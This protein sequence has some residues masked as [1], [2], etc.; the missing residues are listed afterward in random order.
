MSTKTRRSI[1]Q[2]RNIQQLAGA[3]PVSASVQTNDMASAPPA[4]EEALQLIQRIQDKRG[5]PLLTFVTVPEVTVRSD[6]VE[7]VYEQLR[8]I[9]HVPQIDLFLHSAGGQTEVPWRL[10]TLI[11]DFADR[12]A[13]L[14]P[15][16]AYSAATHLAM[17]AD[18][19]IMGPRSELS[20]VDPARAHPLLPGRAEG[21]PPLTVSVQDLRRCVEF[22][23]NEIGVGSPDA[24]AQVIVALFEK[25]H[26]LAIGA[27]QQ[28]YD[29]ARLISR[30]A[31]ATHMDPQTDHDQIERIVNALS[32]EF[33]SHGYWIGWQE[34]QQ[35]GLKVVR[36]DD[37]LW[38]LMWALYRHYKS[39]FT[40]LR[41]TG[42]EREA[43]RPIAWIDSALQ[44]RI[45]EEVYVLPE[46]QRA[47]QAPA[48]KLKTRWLESPWRLDESVAEE[49]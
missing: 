15:G 43:A 40:L 29:L 2:K 17:G 24:L 35:I 38:E 31:L 9:G 18:Q 27:I 32:D 28:S 16:I 7:Q 14:I 44:R 26:P 10:I 1:P 41:V 8:L 13:V 25:V 39:Y 33:F 46:T 11:R 45:L 37:D 49:E 22:V 47:E 5:A 4:P 21:E 34:A 12:F 42:V 30:K 6:V 48:T 20:P 3:E 36:A 23:K 19:I